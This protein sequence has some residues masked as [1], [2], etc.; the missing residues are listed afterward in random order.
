MYVC[1]CVCGGGGGGG[2]EYSCMSSDKA[3]FPS[4]NGFFKNPHSSSHIN[5]LSIWIKV[6]P[7]MCVCV[8]VCV[9]LCLCVYMYV[10]YVCMY[11]CMCVYI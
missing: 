9:C 5:R 1:V 6:R 2:G 4:I 8:C 11:V 10:L 3:S 7:N